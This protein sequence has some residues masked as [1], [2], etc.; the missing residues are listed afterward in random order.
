MDDP[1]AHVGHAIG[2]MTAAF[3]AAGTGRASSVNWQ[4]TNLTSVVA[5]APERQDLRVGG[6][7]LSVVFIRSLDEVAEL[8]PRERPDD[9]LFRLGARRDRSGRRV[10]DGPRRVALGADRDGARLRFHLGRLRHPVRTDAAHPRLVKRAL[11]PPQSRLLPFTAIFAW[12]GHHEERWG[13]K[14]PVSRRTMMWRSGTGD[15]RSWIAP[16]GLDPG[17]H[18]E[19]GAVS[20]RRAL[21]G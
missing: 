6:G 9:H 12:N 5:S 19:T 8:H 20:L 10:P 18:D 16:P 3:Y 13:S 11:F 1:T 2:K 17:S 15:V 7:F 4:N 21:K 14:T